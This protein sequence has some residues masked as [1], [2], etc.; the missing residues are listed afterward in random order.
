MILIHNSSKKHGENSGKGR[1]EYFYVPFFFKGFCGA[2]FLRFHDFLGTGMSI[3]VKKCETCA[4]VKGQNLASLITY[5][6]PIWGQD[7]SK[8]CLWMMCSYTTP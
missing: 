2:R 1:G 7:G 8:R 5:F 4:N 3:S 6:P